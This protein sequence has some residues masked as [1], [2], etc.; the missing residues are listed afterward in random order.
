M[1]GTLKSRTRWQSQPRKPSQWRRK[2]PSNTGD[3]QPSSSTSEIVA[4]EIV[5]KAEESAL[6]V[7]NSGAIYYIQQ[8]WDTNPYRKTNRIKVE[9]K[10]LSKIHMPG[11]AELRKEDRSVRGKD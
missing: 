11:L 4:S 5:E 8:R 3:E 2:T 7:S 6:M 10:M 1:S 9:N